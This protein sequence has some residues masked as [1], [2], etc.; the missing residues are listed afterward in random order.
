MVV[1]GRQMKG[2][3]IPNATGSGDAEQT[4]WNATEATAGRLTTMWE[5]IV[6][7]TQC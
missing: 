5:D 2:I 4:S 6:E 1:E 7:P 3:W